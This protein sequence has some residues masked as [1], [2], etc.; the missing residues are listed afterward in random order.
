VT[1][2]R[3]RFMRGDDLYKGRPVLGLH[4]VLQG[5]GGVTGVGQCRGGC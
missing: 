1:R 4:R 5:G 2:V 3:S